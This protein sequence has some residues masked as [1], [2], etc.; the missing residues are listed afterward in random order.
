MRGPRKWE[1]EDK[2]RIQFSSH[3]QYGYRVQIAL[4]S[5]ASAA[6]AGFSISMFSILFFSFV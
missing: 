3:C 2:K 1:D 4:I 5:E 6:A